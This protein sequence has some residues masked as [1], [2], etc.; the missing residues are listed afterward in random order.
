M[1]E[2]LAMNT[3]HPAAITFSFRGFAKRGGETGHHADG[4]GIAFYE[5]TGCRVFLDSLPACTSPLAQW[6]QNYPIKSRIVM[7]HI[8]K[9]TQGAAGLANCHPFQR[10]W[11]RKAWTFSHNGNLVGFDPALDGTYRPVGETDSELAFCALLQGL[12]QRFPTDTMPDA[13]ALAQAIHD[14]AT[15]IAHFGNFNFLLTQGDLLFAYCTSKL[16]YL[17]RKA[18]FSQAQLVDDDLSIDLR[19]LND[20]SDRMAIVATAPLTRN[21][22]WAQFQAGTLKLFEQG[23]LRWESAVIPVPYFAPALDPSQ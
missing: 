23:E 14:I 13:I 9:A 11:Q 5:D 16:H 20:A 22:V 12:R 3:R 21:E 7:A 8:R 19:E 1:C 18:P 10:E 15:E 2:L 6:V 17:Q 4:W